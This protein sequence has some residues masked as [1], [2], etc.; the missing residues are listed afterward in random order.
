MPPKAIAGPG[1]S[2]GSRTPSEACTWVAEARLLELLS[3]RAC[4]SRKCW[5]AEPALEHRHSLAGVTIRTPN[6]G[7]NVC[8]SLLLILLKVTNY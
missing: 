6:T 3:P 4:I 7:P 5:K 1:Q 2:Q 8:L